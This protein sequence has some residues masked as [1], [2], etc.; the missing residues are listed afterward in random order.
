MADAADILISVDQRHVRNMLDGFKTVELRRRS[1][2]L[3]SGS[4]VWIYSKV[5]R[6]RVEAMGIV[7]KVITGSPPD[8]WKKFKHR[9]GIAKKEFDTYY[10]NYEKCYVIV[11]KEIHTLENSIPLVDIRRTQSKFQPPQFFKRLHEGSPEL[12]LFRTALA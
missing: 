4:R 3:S 7:D 2:K 9:C 8:I 5:P 12:Q 6:G 10:F 11:F 1:L